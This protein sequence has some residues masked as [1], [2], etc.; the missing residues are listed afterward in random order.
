MFAAIAICISLF[1][2]ILYSSGVRCADADLYVLFK[3]VCAGV[4]VL[5]GAVAI[6]LNK[7]RTLP[8]YLIVAGL[9]FG[10][11][12]DLMLALSYTKGEWLFMAGLGAFMLNHVLL[13]TAFYFIDR[14]R[15]RDVVLCCVI[16]APMIYLLTT[17]ENMGSVTVPAYI[18]AF[19][20]AAM[21]AKAISSAISCKGKDM[22]RFLLI[23]GAVMW[24]LSD[25]VL[26]VNMYGN[27]GV[28]LR[29]LS[30]TTTVSPGTWLDFVNTFTYF[31]GQ[32]MLACTVYYYR[33]K[34]LSENAQ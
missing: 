24:T 9:I 4:F 26:C 1:S 29:Q 25:L 6:F 20:L 13:I 10:F 14:F 5:T 32:T 11:A 18:Y 2:V 27:I 12:G 7:K 28:L 33:R 3:S 8:N 16:Y 34:E 21:L 17:F 23:V 22:L 19:A 31:I 15:I 30:L